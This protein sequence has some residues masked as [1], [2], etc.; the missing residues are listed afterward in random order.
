MESRA[1]LYGPLVESL[2]LLLFQDALAKNSDA[3]NSL[4]LQEMGAH[5]IFGHLCDAQVCSPFH[6]FFPN[7]F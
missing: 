5:A 4:Q 6:A 7:L 2:R 1:D 3:R